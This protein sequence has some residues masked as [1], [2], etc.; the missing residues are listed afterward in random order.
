[1][2]NQ[3]NSIENDYSSVYKNSSFG[4]SRRINEI[5]NSVMA[6]FVDIEKNKDNIIDNNFDLND[7]FDDIE[8]I[9]KKSIAEDGIEGLKLI[10]ETHGVD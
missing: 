7:L 10:L 9:T 2:Y 3:N 1:M 6:S 4:K 5:Y 8:I